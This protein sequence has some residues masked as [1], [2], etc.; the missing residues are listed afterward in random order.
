MHGGSPRQ[1]KPDPE[2]VVGLSAV[3]PDICPP[4]N[5]PHSYSCSKGVHAPSE[6]CNNVA[7]A[8]RINIVCEHTNLE[9][10][11]N[12]I[13]DHIPEL[14]PSLWT[15]WTRIPLARPERDLL[16]LHT[17]DGNF[18]FFFNGLDWISQ[19]DVTPTPPDV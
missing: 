17:D 4:T 13:N 12:P 16:E 1:R 9:P 14:F 3:C 11:N 5:Y 19:I 18:F 8:L 7:C 6:K 2:H 10:T 15:L